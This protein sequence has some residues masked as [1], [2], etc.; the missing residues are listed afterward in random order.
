MLS[1]NE[2]RT[3]PDLVVKIVKAVNE[4]LFNE[5]V[6]NKHLRLLVEETK[7]YVR[8]YLITPISACSKSHQSFVRLFSRA[9][10]K[11][12]CLVK[13]TSNSEIVK[14]KK[15]LGFQAQDQALVTYWTQGLG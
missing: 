1:G 14:M 3:V 12:S 15:I 4:R 6:L 5:Y 7:K 11:V 10:S 8:L 9:R 13:I 2:L